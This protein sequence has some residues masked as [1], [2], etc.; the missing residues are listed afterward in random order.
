MKSDIRVCAS[1]HEP[2]YTLGEVCPVCGGETR[3]SA[4]APFSPEDPY[5]DYRRAR[6]RRSR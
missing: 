2:A 6:K 3:N 4:P 5:G 1:G